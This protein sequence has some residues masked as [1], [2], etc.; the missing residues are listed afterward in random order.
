MYAGT[1]FFNVY[2]EES[3]YDAVLVTLLYCIS[4]DVSQSRQ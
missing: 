2:G 3:G 1:A 4:L